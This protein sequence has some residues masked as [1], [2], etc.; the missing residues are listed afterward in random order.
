MTALLIAAA[1][2]L[3]PVSGPE[4]ALDQLDLRLRSVSLEYP[5]FGGGGDLPPASAS[6]EHKHSL[7]RIVAPSA[8][9]AVAHVLVGSLSV[10][11]LSP[12]PRSPEASRPWA[13]QLGG[14]GLG[15]AL[16]SAELWWMRGA[17]N[18]PGPSTTFNHLTVTMAHLLLAFPTAI[19][20]GLW[21]AGELSGGRSSRSALGA[22]G[23]VTG[24][25]LGGV[26]MGMACFYGHPGDA[27]TGLLAACSAAG[28]AGLGFGGYELLRGR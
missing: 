6:R 28:A 19:G 3:S 18:G 26:G 23:A 1:V 4:V 8:V 12:S 7:G 13:M 9:A 20:M 10:A 11:A 27:S 14:A 2:S 17:F 25:L 22:V 24:S 5:L 15:V 16:A 21:A